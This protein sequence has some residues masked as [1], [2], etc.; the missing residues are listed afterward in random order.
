MLPFGIQV[1]GLVVGVLFAYFVLPWI[2]G[3]VN[4]NR[5]RNETA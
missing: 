4:R 5:G 1:K 3:F 2:L